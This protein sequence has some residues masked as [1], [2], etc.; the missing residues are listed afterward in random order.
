[1]LYLAQAGPFNL[2]GHVMFSFHMISMALSYLVA[3]PLMMKGLPTWV[4]RG[5]V[6]MLP[7]RQFFLPGASYCSSGHVQRT[8]FLV[9][10]AHCA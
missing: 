9:S 10:S 8:I 5:I 6:R 3:P 2:L 7:T 1:M 4:W